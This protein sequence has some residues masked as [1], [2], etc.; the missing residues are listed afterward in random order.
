MIT[1]FEVP[2]DA[3]RWKADPDII[4]FEHT[5]ELEPLQEII[6]QERGVSALRFGVKMKKPGYNIFVTGVAGSGRLATVKKVLQEITRKE[7]I[8]E[9]LCYVHNFSDPESPILLTGA[10]GIPLL[11]SC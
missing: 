8:P 9:D 6:G 11:Y 10:C 3:L 5:S 4:P 7:E 1:D 2:V